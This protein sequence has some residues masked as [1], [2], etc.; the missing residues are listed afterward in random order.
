MP[1]PLDL[2]ALARLIGDPTRLTML[3]ALLT[4]G[5]LSAGELAA[6]GG[7]APQTAS[8]HLS[9]LQAGG[10]IRRVYGRHGARHRMFRLTDDQVATT[11]ASLIALATTEPEMSQ[12]ASNSVRRDQGRLCYGHLGG[13]LGQ[14]LLEALLRQQL[15]IPRTTSFGSVD[16]YQVTATGAAWLHGL[17]IDT[18]ARQHQRRY[19]ARRCRNAHEATAHL[20]GSLAEALLQVFMNRGWIVPDNNDGRVLELTAAGRESFGMPV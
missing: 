15:L 4:Q 8:A 20:S 5:E 16:D 19:L 17:G 11:V 13:T 2:S 18:S 7:V 6:V 3:A 12:L 14:A 10:L 1:E 9:K